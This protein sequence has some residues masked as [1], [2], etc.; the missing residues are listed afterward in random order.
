MIA[1]HELSLYGCSMPCLAI[2]Q[3]VHGMELVC[4]QSLDCLYVAGIAA[5][6]H[7]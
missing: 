1:Q 3:L 7:L 5:A 6:S 2:L 4:E